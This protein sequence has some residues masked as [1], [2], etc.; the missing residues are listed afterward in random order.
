MLG[1]KAVPIVNDVTL[2]GAYTKPNK[3][4]GGFS[5]FIAASSGDSLSKTAQP[6]PGG[7]TGLVPPESAPPLVKAA[8]AVFLENKL[9]DVNATLEIAGSPAD[10]R[11]HEL[12]LALGEGVALILPLKVHLENPFLGGN[13]YVGSDASPLYWELRTDT[14]SPPPPNESITGNAG[15][16]E[17]L[18]EGLI[19]E[20]AGT[21][22]VDNAWSAPAASGCAGVLSLLVDP[23]INAQAGL[24]AKA[25][26]NTAILENTIF[27][28]TAFAVNQNDEENP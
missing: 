23:I 16:I 1:S 4:E 10:I 18:E 27:E 9:T 20:I 21:V 19:V 22:L 17:F 5:K 8:L 7:L 24:P 12:N 13:C 3:E 25:G 14:T 28:T 2:Q 6:V 15:E 11:I 26:H